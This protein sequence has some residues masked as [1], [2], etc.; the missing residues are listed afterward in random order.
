MNKS[1]KVFVRALCLFLAVLMALSLVFSVIS[2]YAVD[3][4]EISELEKKKEE[5]EAQADELQSEIDS[6]ES[7]QT[8]YI[9]RKA[10]LDKKLQFN[11]DEIAIINEQLSL[12]EQ[13][14]EDTKA[15]LE[16]ANAAEKGQYDQLRV[17]MRAMEESGSLSYI[18]IL[19][20]ATSLTDL[21][22]R[23]SDMK[24][25]MT[26]D[27]TLQQ[28]YITT[29]QDVESLKAELEEAQEMQEAVKAELEYKQ[30]QL[31][32]QTKAAYE[33]IAN[34]TDDLDVAKTAYEE[35]A[36][37]EDAL[38]E[39]IS[40]KM[41]ELQ[42]QEA[43]ARRSSGG[44]SSG[45]SGGG[46]AA[47][48][49]VVSAGSFLW[50]VGCYLITSEYG[51]RYHPVLG[52]ERFHAGVDIGAGAGSAISAAAEGTVATAAYNDSYGN[53]VLINHGGGN[54][55]LYAHM[56]S[57]A[58]SAGQYVSQGQ[59]IGYVGSTGLSTGP[60]LHFE[61][62]INGSTVNPLSYFSGYTIYNG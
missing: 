41:K 36:E 31:E 46:G 58:V 48:P 30:L 32:A 55:T 5:L 21:L 38:Q 57:M 15:E 25:I 35:F 54:A 28:E 50:P 9:D 62:R 26:Y 12:Y 4:K 37:D 47:A 14:I 23:V 18:A 33:M 11:Q 7:Q 3:K 27:Q 20:D 10:A 1:R 16:K 8:R 43:A 44:G 17:R 45:G 29:R 61:V 56:S 34:L 2:A 51:Y 60:H 19:F 42:A 6:M 39:E 40:Q 49:S 59:V 13:E 52:Y 22:S 53:Y 24:D